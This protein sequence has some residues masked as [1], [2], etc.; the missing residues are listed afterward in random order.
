MMSI[1]KLITA[2]DL[3]AMDSDAPYELIEGELRDMSPSDG[4]SSMIG[5]NVFAALHAYVRREGLGYLTSE[6]G[7]YLLSR[8]PDTVVA[9]DVGFISKATMPGGPKPKEFIPHPPDL[10]VEVM[11]G[12]DR[13]PEAARKA[14]RYLDAGTRLVWV[15]R[16]DDGT[17]VVFASGRPPQE[18]KISD[19][20][21]GGD[22]LPGF[23]LPL[24]DVFPD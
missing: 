24:A 22:V 5:G 7:G 17:A 11:S 4:Y 18:L 8:N 14:Q 2:E 3:L 19:E 10:A 16:P 15:L 1:T 6:G 23:R 13:F 12:P 9:P 21:N 20:L